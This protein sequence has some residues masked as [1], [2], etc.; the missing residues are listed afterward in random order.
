[1]GAIGA[2]E[3]GGGV[4]EVKWHNLRWNYGDLRLMLF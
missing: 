4:D 2:G 3:A 1:M